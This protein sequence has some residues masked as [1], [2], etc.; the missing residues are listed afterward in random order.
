MHEGKLST[1]YVNCCESI[2]RAWGHRHHSNSWPSQP[3]PM[4]GFEMALWTFLYALSAFAISGATDTVLTPL[5]SVSV[6]S[7]ASTPER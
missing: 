7:T 5:S 3:I 6:A 4:I 1:F 2:L